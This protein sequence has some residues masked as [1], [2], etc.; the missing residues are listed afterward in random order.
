MPGEVGPSALGRSG[1]IGAGLPEMGM[2]G[3]FLLVGDLVRHECGSHGK[4]DS[5]EVAALGSMAM[6]RVGSVAFG[7]SS[8]VLG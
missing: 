6:P 3:R 4:S 7:G 8:T 5:T 1:G 2:A